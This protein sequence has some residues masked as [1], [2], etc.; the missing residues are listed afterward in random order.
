MHSPAAAVVDDV[1][2]VDAADGLLELGVPLYKERDHFQIK[3]E[4]FFLSLSI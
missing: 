4:S 2:A 1:A 3:R